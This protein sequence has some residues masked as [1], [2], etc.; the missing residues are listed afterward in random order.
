[1]M[2][3]GE[4]QSPPNG[5]TQSPPNGRL[6]FEFHYDESST[7]QGVLTDILSD[8]VSFK[9]PQQWGNRPRTDQLKRLATNA[10]RYLD[11]VGLGEASEL[12]NCS[13][14]EEVSISDDAVSRRPAVVDTS[15]SGFFFLSKVRTF[16]IAIIAM[17]ARE[18]LR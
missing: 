18:Y 11:R 1:M 6:N 17:A 2:E 7:I 9:E 12:I 5:E 10:I 13:T 15:A 3:D 4:T 16:S 14:V 8:L